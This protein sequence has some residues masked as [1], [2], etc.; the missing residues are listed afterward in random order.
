VPSTGET[1]WTAGTYNTG[2]RRYKGRLIYEVVA[3]PS[4]T[5]DPE[6]G[7]LADPPT[8]ITVGYVNR[9]RMF[10]GVIG[11]VTTE[12]GGIDVTIESGMA[13]TAV[14]GFNLKDAESVTITVTDPVDGLVY[15]NTIELVDN[16]Q[17]VDWYAYFFEPI[18]RARSFVDLGLPNY[19]NAEVRIEIDGAGDV[20]IGELV[21]GRE[22][23]LGVANY[24]TSIQLLD[25]SRKETD[26]FGNIIV[27]PR[28]T[29]KL[30]NYEVTIETS[31]VNYVFDTL[32][33]LTSVPCVWVGTDDVNDGTLVYGY[34]RDSRININYP[35]ISAVSIQVQG[36][37]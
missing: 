3:S 9:W 30:V 19:A 35:S 26:A 32:S 4:T 20:S 18:T 24:G 10:D 11:T 21:L 12:T 14:A 17:I 29:S 16:S 8:W 13:T 28:R 34:Y 27:V 22:M 5:D 33:D 23:T 15:D 6:V 7:V 25:F 2:D 36:L 31:R 37:I 1:L